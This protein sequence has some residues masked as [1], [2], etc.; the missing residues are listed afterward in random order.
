MKEERGRREEGR[1]KRREDVGRVKEEE[2]GRRESEKRREGERERG[3]EEERGWKEREGREEAKKLR[4]DQQLT[5]VLLLVVKCGSALARFPGTC[6]C[7][8]VCVHSHK[9]CLRGDSL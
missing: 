4:L 2:R 5:V 7:V 3:R 6:V 1:G 9:C 8:Y